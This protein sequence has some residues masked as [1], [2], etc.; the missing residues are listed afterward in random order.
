MHRGFASRQC[1][2]Q[3]ISLGRGPNQF[4]SPGRR[5]SFELG[6]RDDFVSQGFKSRVAADRIE[7]GIDSDPGSID[8]VVIAIFAFEAIDRFCLIAQSDVN[9]RDDV[10]ADEFVFGSAFKFLNQ[11]YC[12]VSLAAVRVSAPEQ[13][14]DLR[15]IIER[16]RF[17]VSAIAA[18]VSPFK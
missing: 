5:R 18:A 4:C 15:I 7:H 10:A 1:V 9:E 8:I 11:L 17:F 16:A 13:A 3:R 6:H 14:E 12:L 2:R